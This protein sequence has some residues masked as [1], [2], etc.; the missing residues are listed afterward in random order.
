MLLT[1]CKQR[2]CDQGSMFTFK[3]LQQRDQTRQAEQ[4]LEEMRVYYRKRIESMR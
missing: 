1:A 4:C 2:Q 3:P